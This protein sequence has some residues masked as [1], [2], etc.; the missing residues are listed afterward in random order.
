MA[1]T[2]MRENCM[3]EEFSEPSSQG[4]IRLLAHSYTPWQYYKKAFS[5][6]EALNKGTLFPELYGVYEIPK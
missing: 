5:P 6:A 2:M 3:N 1:K 4:K